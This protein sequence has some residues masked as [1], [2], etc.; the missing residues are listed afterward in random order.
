MRLSLSGLAARYEDGESVTAR[1]STARSSEAMTRRKNTGRNV[2][3]VV[4]MTVKRTAPLVAFCSRIAWYH[5]LS[6]E[7][8]RNEDI[9]LCLHILSIFC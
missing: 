6:L 8:S 7:E 4:T 1:N 3:M 9:F 5:F 2:N